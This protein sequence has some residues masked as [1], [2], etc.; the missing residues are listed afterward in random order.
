MRS[1]HALLGRH[2]SQRP[3]GDVT[4]LLIVRLPGAADT[5]VPRATGGNCDH[6]LPLPKTGL[7]RTRFTHSACRRSGLRVKY[8]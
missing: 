7:F 4:C 5:G 6:S 1:R 3:K 2:P 8:R